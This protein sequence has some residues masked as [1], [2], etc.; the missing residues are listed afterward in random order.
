MEGFQET[1]LPPQVFR[2]VVHDTIKCVCLQKIYF[3]IFIQQRTPALCTI[4]FW[5]LVYPVLGFPWWLRCKESASNAGDQGSIP[6][7]GRS[8]G[9][10]N[11]TPLQYS[12][13]KNSMGRGAWQSMGPQRVRHDGATEYTHTSSTEQIDLNSS[14]KELSGLWR[15]IDKWATTIQC[16][17]S[18]QH[19]VGRATQLGSFVGLG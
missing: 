3:Y 18:G 1:S 2:K 7:L 4:L 16:E 17:S 13:L 15:V 9:V 14:P 10:G 5:M 11:S 8:P 6:Q 12:C 19:W